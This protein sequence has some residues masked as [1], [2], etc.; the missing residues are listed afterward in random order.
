MTLSFQSH[1]LSGSNPRLQCRLQRRLPGVLD[2][3]CLRP[4]RLFKRNKYGRSPF[5][6]GSVTPR[7]EPGVNNPKTVVCDASAGYR[8]QQRLARFF[9][10]RGRDHLTA[11][12]QT[13]Y[14]TY[15]SSWDYPRVKEWGDGKVGINVAIVKDKISTM[16]SKS[17]FRAPAS[18]MKTR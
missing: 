8:A 3:Y 6:L 17:Y 4:F 1:P 18:A 15:R 14:V 16:T 11:S 7:P 12:F 9:E 2:P 10:A 5:V 13:H